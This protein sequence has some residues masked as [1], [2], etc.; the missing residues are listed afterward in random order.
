MASLW[1]ASSSWRDQSEQGD[2]RSPQALFT[3]ELVT[4]QGPSGSEL[5]L[6]TQ[7]LDRKVG[8]G[9]SRPAASPQL[10]APQ[11]SPP[12]DPSLHQEAVLCFFCGR[13]RRPPPQQDRAGQ[14]P[15]CWF[16]CPER[17]ELSPAGMKGVTAGPVSLSTCLFELR[18][19]H[20]PKSSPVVTR[21]LEMEL[22]G[23]RLRHPS[24]WKQSSA[25]LKQGERV[26]SRGRLC[27]SGPST[28]KVSVNGGH[29]GGPGSPVESVG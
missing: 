16:P 24:F 7:H 18:G 3:G 15:A 10:A 27:A 1:A 28:E 23:P 5:R 26:T 17:L 4:R 20:G 12:G 14:A 22:K 29:A 6:I 9:A 2:N 11:Q 25:L 13:G 8:A 21:D 19:L